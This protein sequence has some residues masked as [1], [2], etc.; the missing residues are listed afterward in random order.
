MRTQSNKA[1]NHDQDLHYDH[2]PQNGLSPP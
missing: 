1:S 2:D